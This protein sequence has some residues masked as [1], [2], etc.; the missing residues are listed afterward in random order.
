MEQ[1]SR[2]LRPRPKRPF[3]L[4][5]SAENSEPATPVPEEDFSSSPSS[6]HLDPRDNSKDIKDTKDELSSSSRTRSILNLT[7]STLLGIYSPTALE[8]SSST[9]DLLPGST[10]WGTGAQT[11]NLHSLAEEEGVQDGNNLRQLSDIGKKTATYPKL[12]TDASKTNFP[13]SSSSSSAGRTHFFFSRRQGIRGFILRSLFLFVF[14][15]AYGTIISHFHDSPRLAP[16]KMENINHNSWQYVVFWGV[17]GV[18]L[19]SLL[20]WFDELWE[21]FFS[22]GIGKNASASAITTT[23]SAATTTAGTNGGV[24]G[25]KNG[26]GPGNTAAPAKK[27]LS[28]NGLKE[29]DSS[30]AHS[31]ST[32]NSLGWDW[33]PVVRSI[34]AFVGIAFAI[35][36]LYCS[37]RLRFLFK[38]KALLTGNKQ[39]KLPWQST[40]QV[41]LTLSLVNPVLWYIIDRTKPGFI[42]STVIGLAG[43][44]ALLGINPEVVPSPAMSSSSSSSSSAGGFSNTSAFIQEQGTVIGVSHE[45][46]A[47]G[48]WI[49]SVL[50][51]SCVCFGNIG[52]RLALGPRR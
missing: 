51:C 17:A 4:S 1:Q 6:S 3:E 29:N 37:I 34:G 44:L 39:R 31:R 30:N 36:C 50:F 28:G 24:S 45:T 52:R 26:A 19:G 25:S 23:S 46:I 40:L 33:N 35:V 22:V 38:K 41:S 14:G 9:E 2:L 7:S 43:M 16:I 42:L 27:L 47:V 8:D 20:P 10:P 12:T 49:A 18:A 21:E 48:T 11:P 32:T 13:L 5:P 15:V